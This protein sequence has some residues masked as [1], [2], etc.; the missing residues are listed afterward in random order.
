MGFTAKKQTESTTPPIPKGTYQAV[1]YGI[2]DIGTQYSK[3]FDSESHKFIVLWEIPSPKLRLKFKDGKGN[4]RDLPRT[5]SKTYTMSLGKKSNLR[6]DLVSLFGQEPEDNYDPRKLLNVNC[7]LTIV[8]K[9][10]ETTKKVRATIG[11]V[12]SL[13]DGMTE[14]KPESPIVSYVIE[15]DGIDNI[16]KNIPDWIVDDIKESGEY[17]GTSS[18]NSQEDLEDLPE[19]FGNNDNEPPVTDNDIPF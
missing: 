5:I 12:S 13:M 18:T 8:H 2:V 4:E 15:E 19:Y 17:K 10:N 9:V 16:P 6:A 1:C 7:L 3:M 11:S 14:I